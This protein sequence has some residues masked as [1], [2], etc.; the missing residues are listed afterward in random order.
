MNKYSSANEITSIFIPRVFS[1]ITKERITYVVEHKVPLGKVERIDVVNIDDKF[2]RVFIHFQ[3]WYDTEFVSVFKKLLL[4]ETKQAKIVY[5]DPWYWIVLKNTNRM[6]NGEPKIKLNLD[7]ETKQPVQPPQSS[8]KSTVTFTT[9][10]SFTKPKTVLKYGKSNWDDY[11]SDDEEDKDEEKEEESAPQYH[12]P[13]LPTPPPPPYYS[14]PYYQTPHQY[15]L[16]MYSIPIAPMLSVI[17]P[18]LTRHECSSPPPLYNE[19][20][21]VASWNGVSIN[22]RYFDEYY[23]GID[24]DII[25]SETDYQ[26]ILDDLAEECIQ[27]CYTDEDLYNMEILEKDELALIYPPQCVESDGDVGFTYDI[28]SEPPEFT[29]DVNAYEIYTDTN[30]D[31]QAKKSPDSCSYTKKSVLSYKDKLLGTTF[32]TLVN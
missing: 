27:D 22:E 13:Y 14:C 6:A 11:Y 2:N 10:T 15:I 16:P 19:P 7:D 26:E 32:K 20:F 30:T 9:D 17:P 21:P 18:V 24:D 8:P 4:D 5:D 12:T 29:G 1:N 28:Y 31:I 25:L 23:A 3:S